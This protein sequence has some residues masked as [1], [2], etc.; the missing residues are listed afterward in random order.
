MATTRRMVDKIEFMKIRTLDDIGAWIRQQSVDPTHVTIQYQ[1]IWD[2]INKDWDENDILAQGKHY[3]LAVQTGF[4]ELSHPA[5]SAPFV[6]RMVVIP[7]ID[8]SRAYGIYF[9]AND[10]LKVIDVMIARPEFE[11]I[12]NEKARP[13]N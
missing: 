9:V 3:H 8:E 1:Q 4:L 7:D 11:K 12:V 10:E 2:V 5:R 13:T 6:Y